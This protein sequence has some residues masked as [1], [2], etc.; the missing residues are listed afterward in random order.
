MAHTKQLT[1]DYWER[2]IQ[3]TVPEDTVTPVMTPPPLLPD[4]GAATKEA[5][6]NPIGAPSLFDLARQVPK[7]GKVVIGHDDLTRPALPRKIMI[8]VIMEVLNQAG[9]KDEQVFLLSGNGNHCKWS[10]N[11]FRRYFGEELYQRFAPDGSASRLLNHDCHDPENLTYM[12]VTELGDY[13]EYNSLLA[14]A[15]LFIYNGSVLPSNWGGMTGTGIIIGYASSRSMVSTHGYPVVHHKESCH[16]DQRTMYYRKHKEVIHAHIEKFTGKRVFYVDAVMGQGT[17]LAGVFAGYSPEL[18]EPTW[19][20]CEDLYTV[21]VPQADVVILSVPRFGLY[22]ETTNPL[23]ALAAICAPPRIWNNKPMLRKGGVVI[24]I[25]RCTGKIDPVAHSSYR[26]VFGLYGSCHSP[27]DMMEFEE[28]FLHR[29][30]LIFDYRYRGSY[31]PIHPFWLLYESQYILEHA[32]KVIFA[33]VPTRENPIAPPQLEGPGGPGACR[34]MGVTPAR[35]FDHAWQITENT[36]GK[37]LQ[38]LAMPE[39]WTTLRPRLVVK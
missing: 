24:G 19:K 8:P 10:Q 34:H 14:E 20:L 2:K 35:D 22:G 7:G 3:I 18:N 23:I 33:G 36:L 17:Q 31:A 38:V 30:D 21:E 16:G 25:V 1:A 5:L 37:N 12:G 29:E 15:D 13:V 32:S 9:V 11:Q 28:E 26:E 6:L 27:Y 4:P 39:F